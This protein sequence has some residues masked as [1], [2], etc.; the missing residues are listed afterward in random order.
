M[1]IRIFTLLLCSLFVAAVSAQKPTHVVKIVGSGPAIDG[2]IDDM[3][4]DVEANNIDKN[5]QSETPTLGDA[6]E[7]YWKMVWVQNEGIYLL[8]VVNDDNFYPA[9]E[10]GGDSWMF[11]KPEVYFDCNYILEDDGGAS[12]EGQPGNG[13]HQCAPSFEEGKHSG[14]LL[15]AGTDGEGDADDAGVLYSYM[16][17]DPDYIAEFF[18][19]LEYLTD[20]NGVINDLSEPIGFDVTIIDQD[21]GVT[22]TRHRAVWANTGTEGDANE[23]WNSMDECGTLT[24]EGLGDKTYVESITLTAEDITMNNKPMQIQ[25][26]VLPLDATNPNLAWSVE[27]VTGRAT[28]NNKGVVTPILDGLVRITGAA[29][30]GSYLEETVDVNISGQLVAKHELNLIRNGYFDEYDAN[31]YAL[32]WSNNRTVVDGAL[33]IPAAENQNANYWDESTTNQTG[34][35]CNNVDEYYFGFTIWSEAPDTF[36]VDFEDPNDPTGNYL[37]YGASGHPDAIEGRSE[38]VFVTA[39]TPTRYE[40]DPLTFPNLMDYTSESMNFM[41]G[42]HGEGGVY[43]DSVELIN[44]NDFALISEPYTMVE[45][46]NVSADGGAS[47]VALGS[48]LQM[49]AEVLPGDA[50]YT[51][52][53]WSVEDGTG[54]A[55]IDDAGVLTGDSV[56][57]VMVYAHASDD[58]KVMGSMEI[59]VSWPENVEQQA[60]NTLKV[61]PNPAV[62]ELNVVLTQPGSTVTIYNSVGMKVDEAFVTG[63]EHRFNISSYASGLYFVKTD[64]LV[65]KFIK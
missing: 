5:F 32:E 58:S 51:D 53:Y 6:G 36:Y 29:T 1:K 57:K 35:G 9:Y 17:N 46:I 43:L 33:Y 49:M 65:T 56:G 11:D 15:D 39:T 19:P 42:L 47:T 61:Y 63:T 64:N 50:A 37:R 22:D 18:F 12:G 10:S 7:T 27:N 16:V 60:V 48:T 44:K 34:F 28:V 40:M 24:F 4:L 38:W 55:S 23:S 62:S 26:E 30:D 52:V 41:G 54:Y 21:E 20:E 14:Q 45:T 3:W 25:A 59:S 2:V 8:L 13:H 31:F